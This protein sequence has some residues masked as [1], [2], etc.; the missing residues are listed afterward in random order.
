[1]RQ[2][3]STQAAT[4][5]L[6][7]LIAFPSV[8]ST[9]N[10]AVTDWVSETVQY[11]GF[12]VAR[13]E[14]TDGDG[15][16]KAN[17]V[18]KRAPVGDHASADKATSPGGLAYFCHTDVVPANRWIGPHEGSEP[19]TAVDVN[20]RVYG[21]G[22][23]DMKGSLAAMLSA[24][25][26]VKRDEQTRPLW[27]VCT[28]DEE[29]GF[30]GAKHLVEHCDAYREL[31]QAQPTAI[32]GEPTELD[33]VYAHKGIRG[34]KVISRGL[35]GH[36]ATRIGINANEAMVPMLVK[37]AE[38]C[39]RTRA[40]KTLH[41]DRFDP[42]YLSWN[43]GFSDHSDV[44]N[45]T[46]ARSDAWVCIRP[47]PGIDGESLFAE[48]Q[49]L[50]DELGLEFV[51]FGG[52][53]PLW[54]EPDTDA[55]TEMQRIAGGDRKTV[56][57]ATDGGVFQELQHRVVIGPGSIEQAHTVDEWISLEQLDRGIQVY[58]RAVRRWCC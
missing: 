47:M 37:L 57:Y 46:P 15:K 41:D 33:V 9:S 27:L 14:Y 55:V 28:A 8:S 12:S 36:S 44:V 39:E 52:C 29:V 43:F 23:C 24:A 38:L 6:H 54:T 4:Q 13:T 20:Q 11:L 51:P 26:R 3:G 50:A 40:D 58:E 53:G 30:E 35:A 16:C 2:D 18:A 45:I 25:A 32:I 19:F 21:R 10:V 5:S 7:Q 48:V 31:V 34:F 22:A 1:M 17:L 49:R 56:C 42:P